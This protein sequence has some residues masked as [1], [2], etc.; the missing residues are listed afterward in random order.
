MENKTMPSTATDC[1]TKCLK[2]VLV[3]N[4]KILFPFSQ[5][6]KKTSNLTRSESSFCLL[7]K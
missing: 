7:V 5:I 4:T 3:Q 1:L 6:L 2:L